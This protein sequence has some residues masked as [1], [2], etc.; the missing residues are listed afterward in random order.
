MN[1]RKKFV[2]LLMLLVPFSLEAQQSKVQ[3]LPKYDKQKIHFGFLLGINVTD[4]YIDRD[5]SFNGDDSLY[6]VESAKQSGFNL[7]I[8]SNLRLG[9]HF[10]LRFCPDLS[11]AQRD[12]EY[13]LYANGVPVEK[14][15]KKVESSFL[16]FPLEL[17]FKSERVNNYRIFALAGM[18]YSIDMVSQAKVKNKDKQYVKLNRNDYGYTIGA[19]IDCYMELFKFAVELKM[20]QGLNNLLVQDASIYART[21]DALRSKIFLISFTFE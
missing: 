2:L 13:A 12:L 16:E 15:T 3:N 11:F 19:G 1:N 8:V 7:G 14:V 17:K 18:K 10:D 5:G 21:L 20:Y 4:F 6:T 9:N